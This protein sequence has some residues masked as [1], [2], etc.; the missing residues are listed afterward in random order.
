MPGID[1]GGFDCGQGSPAIRWWR[2]TFALRW[3]SR[4]NHSPGACLTWSCYGSILSW[5]CFV[6]FLFLF[7]FLF[8]CCLFVFCFC[9]IFVFVLLV[10]CIS[11]DFLYHLIVDNKALLF[12]SVCIYLSLSHSHRLVGLVVK[13]PAS[14]AEDRHYM[15]LGS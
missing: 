6:F 15:L 1:R 8:L 4:M 7:L 2:P 5:I 3:R 13:A 9:F 14:R 11:L 10:T 12:F